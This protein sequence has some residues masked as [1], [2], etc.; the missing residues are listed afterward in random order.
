VNEWLTVSRVKTLFVGYTVLL[1]LVAVLPINS[2]GA[3]INHTFI[4][5]IRLD[6]LLHFVIFLP[7]MFLMRKYSGASFQKSTVQP[8]IWILAGLL[9]AV[10]TEM[11][12]Y[13]LPY[14]A[15]NVND[16]LANG[17]GVLLGSVV[18]IR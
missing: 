10:F 7:W 6:Y 12:Q 17:V 15:F 14:R 16:L 9:F 2:A 13:A 8:L 3:T 11:V 4:I 5:S 18:F 1:I